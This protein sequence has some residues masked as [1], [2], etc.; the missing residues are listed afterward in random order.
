MYRQSRPI[1][2]PK[3]LESGFTLIELM[4][5][6]VLLAI[7]LSIGIPNYI[8]LLERNRT[9]ATANEILGALQY[10]RN[11]AVR[12]NSTA[13]FCPSSDAVTCAANWP[14][15][16]G[17]WIVLRIPADPD[18]PM[19]VLPAQLMR[20]GNVVETVTITGPILVEFGSAGQITGPIS[21]INV[22]SGESSRCVLLTL[23]G[24]AQV[25]GCG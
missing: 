22:V 18:D 15:T 21:N 12:S 13:Q 1:I 25:G 20:V 19:N 4:V 8:S 7:I 5:V 3:P 24:A 2:L 9:T 17:N 16:G 23:S 10:A 6:T 11:E 14:A